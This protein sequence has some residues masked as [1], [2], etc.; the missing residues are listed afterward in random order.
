MQPPP[1]KSLKIMQSCN[2]DSNQPPTGKKT[3]LGTGG[4]LLKPLT[5]LDHRSLELEP[6]YIP[7][8]R[9][10]ASGMN[11][12]TNGFIA[13]LKTKQKKFKKAEGGTVQSYK[14]GTQNTIRKET[15][16]G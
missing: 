8:P 1:K 4:S 14:L 3:T 5:W 6:S 13:G 10:P 16:I 9:P 7:K 15:P 11:Y 12:F 2:R